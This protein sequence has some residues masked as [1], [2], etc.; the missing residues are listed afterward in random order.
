MHPRCSAPG[1]RRLCNGAQGYPCP[2]R[3][4]R[5]ELMPASLYPNGKSSP[6]IMATE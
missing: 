2:S 1:I 5:G 3:P 6:F 4:L